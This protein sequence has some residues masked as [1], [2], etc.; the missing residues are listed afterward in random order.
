MN[1]LS[2]SE[3]PKN[4]TPDGRGRGS[5]GSFRNNNFTEQKFETPKGII[6]LDIIC[7]KLVDEDSEDVEMP[8]DDTIPEDFDSDDSIK[9]P[10]FD[11]S[12][13]ED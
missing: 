8:G 6:F 9:D 11:I 13:Q 2:I 4:N 5:F 7:K 3:N 1:I 10:D 12:D